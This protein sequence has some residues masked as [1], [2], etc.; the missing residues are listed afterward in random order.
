MRSFATHQ[1]KAW[2]LA[3]N[4]F[5]STVELLLCTLGL[6]EKSERT[7]DCARSPHDGRYAFVVIISISIIM[8]M[9]LRSAR[10]SLRLSV[11]FS[12]FF[13]LFFSSFF[14]NFVLYRSCFSIIV[15]RRTHDSRA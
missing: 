4:V 2:H 15:K 9:E 8:A 3:K 13:F 11:D 14:F 12:F 6:C 10:E 5:I 7:S 1:L